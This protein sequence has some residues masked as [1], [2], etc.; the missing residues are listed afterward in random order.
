M[1]INTIF[2]WEISET[3][4]SVNCG[5]MECQH[6]LVFLE[7]FILLL[8]ESERKNCFYDFNLN[9]FDSTIKKN[10]RSE[11]IL[12]RRRNPKSSNQ[13]PTNKA[14]SSSLKQR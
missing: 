7:N 6:F 13:N 9:F 8:T 10:F 2:L 1:S 12:H 5:F 14:H 11:F 4:S 3:L